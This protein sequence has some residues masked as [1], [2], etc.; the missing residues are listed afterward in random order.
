MTNNN[1]SNLEITLKD[2]VEKLKNK[3]AE[4]FVFYNSLNQVERAN[5]S[6]G[7]HQRIDLRHKEREKYL[8][9][10]ENDYLQVQRNIQDI[11]YNK[12]FEDDWLIANADQV[13]TVNYKSHKSK[14]EKYYFDLRNI[15]ENSNFKSKNTQEIFLIRQD[16][17][18][19]SRYQLNDLIVLI[20]VEIKKRESAKFTQCL[21]GR[22]DYLKRKLQWR[23]ALKNRRLKKLGETVQ[24]NR[25]KIKKIVSDKKIKYLVHFTTE[26][27]LNSILYEGLVTRSDKH[28]D[29][30]Y[31]AV[32]KQRIDLHYDCLSTSISFPNY[33]MF[34]SKRNTQKG[35]IDQNGESHV[36][37]NWAVIL[38]KAEVLYKFDCKFLNDN[39]A[40]NRVN[41]HSK[42]YNSYKDFIKM[43]VGEEGRRGIPKNYPT[44]PQAEVLVRGNIPTKF[45]EKII[46]NTDDMCN[47]YS[48]LTDVSCAVDYSFFNP[49]RD[50]RVWQNH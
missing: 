44:N 10:I 21:E 6:L 24:E 40:S 15:K 12:V 46:F 8:V 37:H 22:S 23:K 33:K 47:K 9:D 2:L 28:F 18:K 42:K 7:I 25:K 50:W 4:L 31:V 41:L 34:F 16:I 14:L 13:G 45:F 30:R 1:F 29:L 38:L 26:N 27:A 48:A 3:D 49:R 11:E 36:I 32:D 20:G 39:A 35:F 19:E 5:I 43:F 17:D